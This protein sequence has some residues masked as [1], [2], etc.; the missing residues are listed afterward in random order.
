MAYIPSFFS[1]LRKQ[2]E[3]ILHLQVL[4]S[5]YD[6]QA[7]AVEI[8]KGQNHFDVIITSYGGQVTDEKGRLRPV[9]SLDHRKDTSVAILPLQAQG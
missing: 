5:N 1:M 4:L 9:R 8:L 7:D 3:A 2:K 6:N